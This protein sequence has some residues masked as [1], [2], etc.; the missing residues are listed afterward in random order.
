[1][2]LK[3]RPGD[4]NVAIVALPDSAHSVRLWPG[5]LASAEYCLDFVETQTGKPINV[6]DDYTLWFV[7]PPNSPWLQG[8]GP[9]QLI[10]LERSWGVP[11][12]EILEGEEKFVLR[13]GMTCVVR[14]PGKRD[15]LFTVPLRQQ[16]QTPYDTMDVLTLPQ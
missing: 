11:P 13:D 8:V 12:M 3:P 6:P 10:S 14:R 1:M 9:V 4:P 15:A 16:S 7:P 2:Q 5:S